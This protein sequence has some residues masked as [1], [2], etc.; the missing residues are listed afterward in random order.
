[1]TYPPF[2]VAETM[3]TSGIFLHALKDKPHPAL[4]F[5]NWKGPAA[6]FGYFIEPSRYLNLAAMVK[7]GIEIGRRPTG[8]GI[9]LHLHDLAFA[10]YLPACHPRYSLNTLENY[11]TVNGAILDALDKWDLS[12]HLLKTEIASLDDASNHFCMAK[13]TRYD[14]L[15]NGLKVAGGAQRRMQWGLLHQGSIHLKAVAP[16][17]LKEILL[18]DTCVAQ[19]IQKNS[20]PDLPIEKNELKEALRESFSKIF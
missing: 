20:C 2:S 10:F 13:P 7:N 12:L 14:V 3:E 17:L 18:P 11:A 15:V 1:M 8:G 16:E 5:Y 6:T 4:H 19:A 9:L